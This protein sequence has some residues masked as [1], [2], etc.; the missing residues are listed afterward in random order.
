[1]LFYGHIEL[2]SYCIFFNTKCRITLPKLL[3][4]HGYCVYV[5]IMAHPSELW[6]SHC[7]GDNCESKVHANLKFSRS[8]CFNSGIGIYSSSCM[9]NQSYVIYTK[10]EFL[11]ILQH[12]KNKS[13]P[14]VKII[15][16][17]IRGNC[18]T[19]LNKVW[20]R[21]VSTDASRWNNVTFGID[22]PINNSCTRIQERKKK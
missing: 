21:Y 8:S 20:D 3:F 9:S 16:W 17:S 10:C 14:H 2:S 7:L 13:T 4:H 18:P 1:M 19:S 5:Q 6:N 22:K 11:I 12:L 15:P